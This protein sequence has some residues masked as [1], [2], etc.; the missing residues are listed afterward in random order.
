MADYKFYMQRVYQGENG[1][2]TM[3]SKV[4]DLEADFKGLKYKSLVGASQY[5]KPKGVYTESFSEDKAVLAYVDPKGERAQT[6][7]TLNLYFLDPKKWGGTGTGTTPYERMNAL[8]HSFVETFKNCYVIYH[9]TAR[10]RYIY[11][12]MEDAHSVSADRLIGLQYIECQFKFKNVYGQTFANST[13]IDINIGV[14]HK[15]A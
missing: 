11:M 5:G 3:D 14:E 12:Y 15:K 4:Y 13:D 2:R 10:K 1:T 6:D 9:D 8:Y 7:I